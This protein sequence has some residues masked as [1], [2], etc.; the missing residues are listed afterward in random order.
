[1]TSAIHS[2]KNSGEIIAGEVGKLVIRQKS[3]GAIELGDL[4]VEE[5][6]DGTKLLLQVFDLSYGSQ[7]S[8][9][10]REMI[11]GMRLEGLGTGL[12]LVEPNLRN[13]VIALAKTVLH[14]TEQ[15]SHN[16]KVL[17][18]FFGTVRHVTDKDLDFLTKPT[19]SIYFGD[20]RSGSKKL[21]TAVFLDGKDV[22]SHHILIPAT[23]GRGKSNLVKVM[24]WN[25]LNKDFCGVLVL[26][27]HNEYFG[28]NAAKGLRDHPDAREY[29]RY[30]SANP[31]AGNANVS[32]LVINVRSITPHHFRGIADFSETQQDALA[33]AFNQHGE[34]WIHQIIGNPEIDLDG[35]RNGT[36]AV[37]RRKF[38]RILGVY[39]DGEDHQV[40]F[41]SPI[42]VGDEEGEGTIDQILEHLENGRKVIIDTS[43]LEDH[44]ELLIGSIIAH[45]ILNNYK[46]A[47]EA[48]ELDEKPVISI[49]IEEAPRVLSDE[50]LR[51]VGSNIYSDIAREGRKFKVGLTA[52]T[53]LTSVI[54]KTILANMNTKIILGNELATERN[55]IIQSAS[56]DLSTDDRNIA[57]LDKGEAIISS[58][59]A[60]FAVPIKIP[61]F[62]D[63][64]D[65]SEKSPK[66]KKVN[67]RVVT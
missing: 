4:L 3:D 22:F 20:V 18:V 7:M 25:I 47:K 1:M 46:R 53:Q 5:R 15:S 62:E 37:I 30:Y 43:M 39:L 38:D 17:P 24:L 27:P 60:R 54:P 51:S 28:R 29:L 26:D 66:P 63:I 10:A 12:D 50:V 35:V 40:K 57:S 13:Y 49:V 41:R 31:P 33:L 67:V 64:V 65:A 48:G 61:L 45:G 9:Q 23:T 59:F 42:F 2:L 8:Q 6:A 55:S 36:L 21:D 56:Q 19:D 52:I 16:P 34:E 32:T 14:I 44:A 11:A 58:N